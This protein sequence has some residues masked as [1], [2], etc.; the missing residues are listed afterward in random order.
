V[1][2]TLIR[3]DYTIGESAIAPGQIE[4]CTFPYSANDRTEIEIQAVVFTDRS[5]NGSI[6]AANSILHR[7]E[8]LRTQLVAIDQLLN[9]VLASSDR[10]LPAALTR[11][12]SEVDSLSEGPQ[13]SRALRTGLHD[14][15][16]EAKKMLHD[17]LQESSPESSNLRQRLA[18]LR[19]Q[20]K[21]RAGRLRL[22]IATTF[23]FFP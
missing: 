17:L 18:E 11:L 23:K 3:T 5:F 2:G 21:E 7:R 4:K 13:E 15:K 8:G 20:L 16:S 10:K 12:G 22:P 6:A 14:A 19:R 1:N 9:G